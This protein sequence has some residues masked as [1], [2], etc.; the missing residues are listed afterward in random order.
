[1]KKLLFVLAISIS[2]ISCEQNE[3]YE[4]EQPE[5]AKVLGEWQLYRSEKLESVIDQWTGTDWTYV[6]KWFKNITQNSSIIYE[7]KED[8]TFLDKYADVTVAQGT[9]LKID[10]KNYSFEYSEESKNKNS[11]L[12][13]KSYITF[14]CDNTYSIKNEGNAKSIFYYKTLNETEC[15][16]SITYYVND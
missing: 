8:G 12:S 16:E 3:T 15:S 5:A 13:E 2:F 14:Y 9:W 6:D 11:K 4:L 7:F 1:M 10:D